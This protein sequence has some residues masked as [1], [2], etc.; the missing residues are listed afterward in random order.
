[1]ARRD[2]LTN[3]GP[4]SGNNRSKALNI[5]KR[6]W[7][8]NLQNVRIQTKNGQSVKLR[9]STKTLRTLKKL[10]KLV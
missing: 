1:M 2:Q 7:N 4:L 8:L 9:V 5:T 10:G 3:R 6:K